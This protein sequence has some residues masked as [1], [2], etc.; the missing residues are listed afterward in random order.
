MNIYITSC[1]AETDVYPTSVLPTPYLHSFS[2]AHVGQ[3]FT[4]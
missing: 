4:A 2:F 1:E 3:D